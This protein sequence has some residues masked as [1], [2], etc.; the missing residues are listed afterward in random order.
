[1]SLYENIECFNCPELIIQVLIAF[2]LAKVDKI[3]I[4][5]VSNIY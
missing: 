3:A 4:S 5:N 1:M 2:K